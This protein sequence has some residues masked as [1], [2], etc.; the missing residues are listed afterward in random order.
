MILLKQQ[1]GPGS[2]KE[3]PRAWLFAEHRLLLQID[4]HV[5]SLGVAIRVNFLEQPGSDLRLASK[6]ARSLRT[7]ITM[8]SRGQLETLVACP[9]CLRYLNSRVWKRNAAARNPIHCHQDL[10]LSRL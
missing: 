2:I 4:H 10:R 3:P 9:P 6:I 1:S 7:P 8:R 5:E